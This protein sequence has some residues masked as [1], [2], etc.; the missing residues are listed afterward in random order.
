MEFTNTKKNRNPFIDYPELVDVVFRND[1]EY[2]FHDKGVAKE[3]A[4]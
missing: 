2:V 4:F 1:T 3:L